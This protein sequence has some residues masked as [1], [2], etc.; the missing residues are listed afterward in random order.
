MAINITLI[1]NPI[2]SNWIHLTDELEDY[3]SDC[4]KNKNKN[5][6]FLPCCL[7]IWPARSPPA[8][9]GWRRTGPVAGAEERKDNE[10]Y[11]FQ[12]KKV[13]SLNISASAVRN[14]DCDALS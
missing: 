11:H 4:G 6:Q 14:V 3:D 2:P 13:F 7:N 12:K 8:G 1:R 5:K 9:R 10:L